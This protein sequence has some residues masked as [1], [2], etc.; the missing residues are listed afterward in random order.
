[1]SRN[2][3][4]FAALVLLSLTGRLPAQGVLIQEHVGIR[5]PRPWTLPDDQQHATYKIEKLEVRA[6]IKDQVGASTGF[7]DL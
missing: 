3:L 5:L 1:M 7:P 6:R 4:A 2:L